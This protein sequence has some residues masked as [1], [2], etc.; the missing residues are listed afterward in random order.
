MAARVD[1]SESDVVVVVRSDMCLE[2]RRKS[3]EA[4]WKR[5]KNT[6]V[7][8]TG[9]MDVVYLDNRKLKEGRVVNGGGRR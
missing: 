5:K 7:A 8:Y 4:S 1:A 6:S 3:K 9:K 2:K